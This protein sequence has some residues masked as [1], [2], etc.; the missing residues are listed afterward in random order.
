MEDLLI[1]SG[2]YAA[3]TTSVLT[4]RKSYNR[5]IHA[6]KLVMEA[7]RLRLLWKPFLEWLSKKAGALD[8]KVKQ[9]VH[10]SSECRTTIKMKGF[11]NDPWLKLQGCVERLFSLLD[12]FKSESKEKSKVFGFWVEYIVMVLMLLQFI[13][14]E[15]TGNWKLH[16]SPTAAMIPHF[17][18][19]DR[20]N[21][22]QWLPVYISDM[23][24][25]ESNHPDVYR[26]FISGNHGVAI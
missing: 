23:K 14:A 15:Q 4:L 10:R 17:Y 21:Y 13:K 3:G 18:S 22:A 16:L 11:V 20:L 7:L 19:M 2:V 12:A 26:E 24:M 9:D 8:N 5:G 25:L 6:P 1:E